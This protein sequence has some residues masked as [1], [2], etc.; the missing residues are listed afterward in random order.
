MAGATHFVSDR[1]LIGVEQIGG[2][3]LA[4]LLTV[5]G[6]GAFLEHF[7]V[8]CGKKLGQQTCQI[9]VKELKLDCW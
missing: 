8:V 3:D 5:N 9:G 1:L 4:G 6:L 7:Q 2:D